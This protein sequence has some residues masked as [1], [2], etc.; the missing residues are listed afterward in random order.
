MH[1]DKFTLVVQ[2][3]MELHFTRPCN[4]SP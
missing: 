4:I 1:C 3:L 2:I